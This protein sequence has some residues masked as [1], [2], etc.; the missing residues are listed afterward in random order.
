MRIHPE[1]PGRAGES[2]RTCSCGNQAWLMMTCL[3]ARFSRPWIR[4]VLKSQK[5]MLP[6]PS[7]EERNRPSGEKCG[8]HAYPAIV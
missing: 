2:E 3:C 5:T 6:C 8:S 4:P 1:T 7:P